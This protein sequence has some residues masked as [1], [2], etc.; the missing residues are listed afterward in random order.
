[1]RSRRLVMLLGLSVGLLTAIQISVAQESTPPPDAKPFILP[2]S[3]P[4]GPGTWGFGQAYGNTVGAFFQRDT[5]YR[6]GQGLHFGIDLWMRCETPV[7]AIGAGTVAKVDAP[8]HGSRPHNL[9]LQLDAGYSVLYGHL[10]AR[11]DLEVGQ[12]VEQG[13]F[14]ALSGDSFGTC[15][16]APH[17]HL[18]IRSTNYAIAYNPITLIDADWDSLALVGQ[19]GIGFERDLEN[20]RR[21]QFPDDQPE[22]VFGGPLLNNYVFAWPNDWI[23]R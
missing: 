17:L 4:A 16:S 22:T 6:A 14:V 8:E 15:H 9:L 11:P 20:P 1:M 3:M 13:Q 23:R 5:T 18:E 19:F 7:V 10:F 21:W 2:I 12:R